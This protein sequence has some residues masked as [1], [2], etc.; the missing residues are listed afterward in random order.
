MDVLK[1]QKYRLLQLV[2]EGAGRLMQ[3]GIWALA[4][5]SWEQGQNARRSERTKVKHA[6][7]LPRR[8][9]GASGCCVPFCVALSL[10]PS[11]VVMDLHLVAV[12][13]ACR[14]LMAGKCTLHLSIIHLLP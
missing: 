8:S 11:A 14:A 9:P 3:C 7:R 12:T 13:W 1:K 2:F 4:A 10:L 5:E 6:G